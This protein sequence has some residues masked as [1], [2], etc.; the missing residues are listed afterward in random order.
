MIEIDSLNNEVATYLNWQLQFPQKELENINVRSIYPPILY[1]N[2]HESVYGEGSLW[3]NF[4]ETIQGSPLQEAWIWRELNEKI[5]PQ[6]IDEIVFW[7]NA[8]TKADGSQD[9]PY[10]LYVTL[11]IFRK[12]NIYW[13]VPIS[14]P[15]EW[16]VKRIS[17][18][19]EI[20]ERILGRK[21]N[22]TQLQKSGQAQRIYFRFLRPKKKNTSQPHF[23]KVKEYRFNLDYLVA[24]PLHGNKMLSNVA[25]AIEKFFRE[26]EKEVKIRFDVIAEPTTQDLKNPI[27]NLTVRFKNYGIQ[28]NWDRGSREE[29]RGNYLYRFSPNGTPQLISFSTR[30]PVCPYD[31]FYFVEILTPKEKSK[32]HE[33]L[34]I[35]NQILKKIATQPYLWI[36]GN[37]VGFSLAPQTPDDEKTKQ[38]L[39]DPNAL[40][41]KVSGGLETGEWTFHTLDKMQVSLA[42]GDKNDSSFQE[43]ERLFEE[44]YILQLKGYSKIQAEE[45][46][47][48]LQRSR[49]IQ[50]AFLI[51]PLT[52]PPLLQIHANPQ[53]NMDKFLP[54]LR[55]KLRKLE[56]LLKPS[57]VKLLPKDDLNVIEVIK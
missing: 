42:M 54:F 56:K 28:Q 44:T 36:N 3:L 14:T 4:P 24:I 32:R 38:E 8:N 19:G 57:K 51:T 26:V 23:P 2:R 12:K 41:M 1:F 40:K 13:S 37:K 33:A 53:M 22:L 11:D 9:F 30:P 31:L 49:L 47:K 48:Y 46:A 35:R 50:Q 45:I 6:E 21:M 18:R 17:L 34:L 55:K 16:E 7:I 39:E 10:Y 52:D 27:K 15:G 29:Q 43:R 25:T 5:S 20:P